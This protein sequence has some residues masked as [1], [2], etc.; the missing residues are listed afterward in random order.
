MDH[1][2]WT[3]EKESRVSDPTFLVWK[4]ETKSTAINRQGLWIVDCGPPPHPGPPLPPVD[5]DVD[6]PVNQRYCSYLTLLDL[7]VKRSWKLD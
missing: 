6:V 1:G 7:P 3:M 4:L 2:P 5:V